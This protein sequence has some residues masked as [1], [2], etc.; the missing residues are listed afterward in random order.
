MLDSAQTI[1]RLQKILPDLQAVL[2]PGVGH[3]VTGQADRVT[4][5]LQS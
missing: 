2:L 3:V 4:A 1:A 5:F